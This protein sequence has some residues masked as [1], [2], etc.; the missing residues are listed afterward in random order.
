LCATASTLCPYWRISSAPLLSTNPTGTLPLQAASRLLVTP[1]ILK[2]RS[3]NSHLS[4]PVPPFGTLHL[5]EQPRRLF[6]A[7]SCWFRLGKPRTA[8]SFQG[9]RAAVSHDSRIGFGDR[10][11]SLSG[12]SSSR[13]GESPLEMHESRDVP[14]R[15]TS[16]KR[17]PTHCRRAV[18][19][20]SPKVIRTV[21][22]SYIES[23]KKRSFRDRTSFY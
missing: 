1:R 18:G 8:R 5:V 2:D 20:V 15:A 23:N 4:F 21:L 10:W 12:L 14:S 6:C 7:R 22:A 19:T 11:L 16:A 13:C 3:T 9:V 17:V